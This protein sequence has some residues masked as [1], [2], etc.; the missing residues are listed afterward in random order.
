MYGIMLNQDFEPSNMVIILGDKVRIDDYGDDFLN[1]FA[2]IVLTEG[3]IDQYSI[4]KLREYVNNGGNL[5]PNIIEGENSLSN[6]RLSEMLISLEDG[7]DKMEDGNII[8]KDFDHKEILLNGES[9]FLVV[10]ETYSLFPGWHVK[11]DNKKA[12]LF[13]A[14][15]VVT[16][17]YIPKETEKVNFWYMPRSFVNGAIISILGLIMIIGYF[18]YKFYRKHKTLKTASN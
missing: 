12:E 11:V 6:E 1:K 18:I 4:S 3:S 13:R 9:G 2:S 8:A 17:V 16:A 7:T 5:L 10:S 14:N 15:G